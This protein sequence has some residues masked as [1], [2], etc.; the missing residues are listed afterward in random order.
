MPI[1]K[2]RPRK[3][4]GISIVG[5]GRLGTT[6]AISL[7][8]C[9]YPLEALV[10]RSP[11]TARRTAALFDAHTPV[12]AAKQLDQ[13]PPSRIV[14]VSTPD[15]QITA[16]SKGLAR[17]PAFRSQTP[18]VLHTSGAL[19]STVFSPL[20]KLGWH[21]GSLHPLLSVSESTTAVKLLRGV[22]WCVEGG[23]VA[24]QQARAI[25]RDLKGQSFSID[26][27]KKAL[28]HAAAVMASGN[29]VA[30]FDVAVEML[31]RCGLSRKQARQVLLPL[32]ESTVRN[33][34]R[35]E[36]SEALTGTFSRGDVGT[37]LRH[38]EALSGGSFAEARQLYRL[39]GGR[40]LTLAAKNGLD[41]R[42]SKS[43]RRALR[44]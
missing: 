36:T 14:I 43:I 21:T 5:A 4:P 10:T 9:G 28:Y 24:V 15:D 40:S 41:S 7:R 37:V 25:V 20:A 30:V 31:S 34:S 6:L 13:L 12:L 33:L 3:K 42:T 11:A 26:S 32:L 8:A 19:P 16:I 18:T 1:R 27:E 23:R 2:N 22:F 39:L 44:K 35:S 17:V 38:L 29:V